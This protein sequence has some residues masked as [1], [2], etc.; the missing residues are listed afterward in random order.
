[1]YQSGKVAN[2]ARGQLNKEIIS[3]VSTINR[4][5][6]TAVVNIDGARLT[7][8]LIDMSGSQRNSVPAKRSP[9]QCWFAG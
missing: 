6:V 8:V 1:M 4:R 2:P 3:K 5:L 7:G 9:P